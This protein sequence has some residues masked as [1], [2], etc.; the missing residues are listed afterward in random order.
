[1]EQYNYFCYWFFCGFISHSNLRCVFPY[2]PEKS[3]KINHKKNE[4][5]KMTDPKNQHGYFP[6]IF[7]FCYFV[8]YIIRL[9]KNTKTNK[10][11]K[12]FYTLYIECLPF[13]YSNS[14][15]DAVIKLCKNN[16]ILLSTYY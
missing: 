13:L 9:L 14:D 10:Q 8:L 15:V 7:Y 4:G 6:L 12:T 16:L 5:S 1:M 2:P 3:R 11:T